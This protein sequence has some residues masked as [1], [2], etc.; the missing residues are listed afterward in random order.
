MIFGRHVGN[1]VDSGTGK[2]QVN[3]NRDVW[4]VG[5][6]GITLDELDEGEDPNPYS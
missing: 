2:P 5:G 6:V 3:G 4:A 1:C